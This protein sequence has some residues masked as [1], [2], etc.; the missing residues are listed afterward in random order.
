[1][2][3]A[4]L[5]VTRACGNAPACGPHLLGAWLFF[6]VNVV[7][8]VCTLWRAWNLGQ[9]LLRTVAG[10]LKRSLL[11]LVWGLRFFFEVCPWA[12]SKCP[13]SLLLPFNGRRKW[14]LLQHEPSPGCS[15]RICRAELWVSLSAEHGRKT[16][17]AA[18]LP[19]LPVCSAFY[20]L[21]KCLGLL[22]KSNAGATRLTYHHLPLSSL[23]LGVSRCRR[24]FLPLGSP[25]SF[26]TLLTISRPYILHGI[27]YTL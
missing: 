23:Y 14:L 19:L 26:L 16:P 9:T 4:T 12:V 20:I 24:D 27:T 5:P 21:L 6:A 15:W 7:K 10:A 1:M 13:F 25:A 22:Y 8:S 18:W 11:C 3:A 2:G 17:R